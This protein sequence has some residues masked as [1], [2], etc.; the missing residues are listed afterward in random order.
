MNGLLHPRLNRE[1]LHHRVESRYGT[2]Y[3]AGQFVRFFI[4]M[5]EPKA[6]V[7]VPS[8]KFRYVGKD[9]GL[10]VWRDVEGTKYY[11]RRVT[12]INGGN[13][14]LR[15]SFS[16]NLRKKMNQQHTCIEIEDEACKSKV[17]EVDP[18]VKTIFGRQ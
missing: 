2:G 3:V 17:L 14:W 12:W 13:P 18:G 1:E 8:S 6:L 5:D 11:C 16:A 10:V 9:L 7:L 15:K 4:D